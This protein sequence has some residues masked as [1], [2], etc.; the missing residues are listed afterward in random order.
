M[1][2]YSIRS[3]PT[4]TDAPDHTR[5]EQRR[6]KQAARMARLRERRGAAVSTSI[7]LPPLVH[8][9]ATRLLAMSRR[10]RDATSQGRAYLIGVIMA[11]CAGQSQLRAE[12]PE[13]FRSI[14]SYLASLD[15]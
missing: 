14:K 7:S 11:A 8:E 9:A 1:P 5:A 4:T 13:E 10:G 2:T 6:V 12:M 15:E 3:N